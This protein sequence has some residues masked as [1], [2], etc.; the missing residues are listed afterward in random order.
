MK[1]PVSG[2][3]IT[4]LLI[5]VVSIDKVYVHHRLISEKESAPF[6]FLISGFWI[7]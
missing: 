7:V 4:L 1:L 5:V 6:F 3:K 2:T